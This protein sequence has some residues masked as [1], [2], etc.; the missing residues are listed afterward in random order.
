MMESK[1]ETDPFDAEGTVW[2]YRFAT[3]LATNSA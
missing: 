1:R 2:D 3:T